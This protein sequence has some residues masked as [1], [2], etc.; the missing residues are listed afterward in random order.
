MFVILMVK[1][2]GFRCKLW[3]DFYIPKKYLLQI[4]Q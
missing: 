3:L 1:A 2:T 4:Q